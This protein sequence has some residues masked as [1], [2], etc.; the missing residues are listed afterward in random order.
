MMLDN[1]MRFSKLLD[2]EEN[3]FLILCFYK[4]NI[5]HLFSGCGSGFVHNDYLASLR[6]S[7]GFVQSDDMH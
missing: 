5:I 2:L 7:I 1:M 3:I 6:T 4:R